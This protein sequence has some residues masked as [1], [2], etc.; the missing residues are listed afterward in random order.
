MAESA[1]LVRIAV[2]LTGLPFDAARRD[3][4]ARFATALA[5]EIAGR[6]TTFNPPR[7]SIPTEPDEDGEQSLE[8]VSPEAD[9]PEFSWDDGVAASDVLHTRGARC[10]P[11]TTAPLDSPMQP[12]LHHS[13]DAPEILIRFD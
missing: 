1:E 8:N 7:F 4:V 3:R 9:Q 11:L 10:R 12:S 6:T 2:D 13:N 5:R